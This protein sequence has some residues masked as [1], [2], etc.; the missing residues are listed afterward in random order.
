M[1]V[2]TILTEITIRWIS[3]I[4]YDTQSEMMTKIT[5][6]IFIAQFFNTGLIYLLVYANF[7]DTI[8]YLAQ[9]F[10]GP[11]LDYDS[12]WYSTVGGSLLVYTMLFNS[13]FPQI[14]QIVGDLQLWLARRKDQGW[15]K[16]PIKAPYATKLTQVSQYIKLYS[17]PEYI[18][19][20][21]YSGLLTTVY[22]AMMY[23]VGI[24]VM[25]PIAAFTFGLF[26]I[27]EKWH[28]AYTYQL[29][30]SFDDR[31]TN[32]TIQMLRYSP[33]LLLFN[34]YWMLDNQQIF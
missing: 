9:W 25:F 30:P 18:V 15:E 28:M 19:H 29:P 32:N 34:G 26:W 4:G 11:Y 5:N 23:G 10:R 2:N 13:V 8:P 12:G 16:D 1:V 3:W 21:R 14:M 6:G 22:V 33:I 7:S 17:G 24:P 27:H 20:Y 31:L